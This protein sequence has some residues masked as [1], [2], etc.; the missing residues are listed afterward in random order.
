[1]FGKVFHLWWTFAD[2][3]HSWKIK[4]ITHKNCATDRIIKQ[5]SNGLPT[6]Y[7]T[8]EK[9]I[10]T[11]KEKSNVLPLSSQWNTVSSIDRIFFSS[12][13]IPINN[14]ESEEKNLRKIFTLTVDS[15]CWSPLVAT[16]LY[17]PAF[18]VLALYSVRVEDD[19][20]LRVTVMSGLFGSI[21]SPFGPN[22]SICLAT[23][24]TE[25][26][27]KSSML[28]TRYLKCTH[29]ESVKCPQTEYCRLFMLLHGPMPVVST[30]RNNQ[31]VPGV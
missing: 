1:M 12:V 25:N 4:A 27:V 3:W 20:S 29:W 15:P 9:S 13:L 24:T 10:L 5:P 19:S 21:L 28:G 31:N 26:R 14:L 22:Q 6:I 7:W 2:A 17:V 23:P 8:D 30:F 18:S 16:H 11:W